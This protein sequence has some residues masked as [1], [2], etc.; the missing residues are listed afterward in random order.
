MSYLSPFPHSLDYGSFIVLK[1]SGVN[2]PNF[3][4]SIV[5]AIPVP[6]LVSLRIS[7]SISAEI[8][9]EILVEIAL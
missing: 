5:L 8:T 6:S 7:M 1:S 9:A 2:P 4:F 3:F